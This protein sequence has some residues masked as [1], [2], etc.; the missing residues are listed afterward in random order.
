MTTTISEQD[1]SLTGSGAPTAENAPVSEKQRI[2]SI[3]TL[4]GV[5]LFGILLMNII[6]FA[7]PFAAYTNPA[8]DGATEGVDLFAF[9]FN[10]VMVEGSMRAL[11]SMLFG[12]GML[13]FLNKPGADEAEVKKLFYRRTKL[14]ICFGLVNA[15]LF[16]W[17]G[18]I[19]YAYGVTGLL[20]YYFCDFPAK[21]L[22]KISAGIVA[23]LMLLHTGLHFNARML[24]AEVEA[25]E[26]LPAGTELSEEQQQILETW[27]SFLEQ[28]FA[29]PAVIEEEIETKKSGYIDNFV[30]AASINIF[31]QT[32]VFLTNNVWDVLSMML[33]GMAC[34]KWGLFDASRSMDFYTKLTLISF[35]IAIP[36]NL[37]ETMTFINSGFAH[38]WAPG[39][40]PSYDV[41]RLSLAFG[42]IGLI[43]MICKSGVLT[44]FR[45]GMAAVGQMALTNYLSQSIIC[46]FVFMGFGL[47]LVGELPRHQV[48]YVVFGVWIFQLVF[49]VFWLKSY[50]FGPAEWL[51]RSLTYKKMQPMR[52]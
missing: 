52:L 6:A 8:I 20:L 1:S 22:L 18:D 49:S 36:V 40:R 3:D 13:I 51:W 45:K 50:R 24:G 27:D 16:V 2:Q 41:G 37:V 25:I 42:Y 43:M 35:A 26:S 32:L 14:L 46:N 10:D 33:L 17:I 11:F 4:R 34:W 31:I 47:G 28:Q 19:L 15:Y 23:L 21:K 38:H 48:Y 7:Y 39:A 30:A 44:A 9:A 5:A 12:A 29:S